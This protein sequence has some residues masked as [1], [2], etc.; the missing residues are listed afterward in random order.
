MVLAS[1]RRQ[2][3]EAQIPTSDKD[4]DWISEREKDIAKIKQLQCTRRLHRVRQNFFGEQVIRSF[5]LN[6]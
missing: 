3:G 6:P 4:E 5:N 2:R 1:R